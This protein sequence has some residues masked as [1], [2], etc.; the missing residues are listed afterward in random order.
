M[1][2]SIETLSV[3]GGELRDKAHDSL[4]TP[5][6][7]ATAYPFEN[8]DELHRYL[9]AP[10]DLSQTTL[11]ALNGAQGSQAVA[12]LMAAPEFQRR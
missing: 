1:A 6:I 12:L 9:I 10:D 5:L 2:R 7:L 11:S 4:V 3:H 8:T